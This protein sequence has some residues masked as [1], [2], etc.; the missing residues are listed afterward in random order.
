M[1]VRER[2]RRY[3]CEIEIERKE[4]EERERQY[5]Q[6]MLIRESHLEWEREKLGVI[7]NG[8]MFSRISQFRF[9]FV[10]KMNCIRCNAARQK[11]QVMVLV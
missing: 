1:F 6:Y 4:R 7:E 5:N 10:L 9:P 8:H 2:A 11:Y 3:I